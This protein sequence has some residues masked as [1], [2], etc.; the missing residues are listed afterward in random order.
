MGW[1][2]GAMWAVESEVW[3]VGTMW[4]VESEMWGPC[5]LWRVK[6]GMWGSVGTMW[7]M[8]CGTVWGSVPHPPTIQHL[9]AFT[10]L[11]GTLIVTEMFGVIP[12]DLS[13][14]SRCSAWYLPRAE[15]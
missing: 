5:G 11:F 9:G 6:Y 12:V 3:G 4:A 14:I 15:G 8:S 10:H 13:C 2:V 1:A 7:R